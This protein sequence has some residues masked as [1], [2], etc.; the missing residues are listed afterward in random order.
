M[1][2]WA[3]IMSQPL[4]ASGKIPVF[5]IGD[6]PINFVSA[7]DVAALA[8]RAVTDPGLRGQVLQL[9]GPDNLT[10]NQFAAIVQETAGHRG[11]VRHIPRLALQAMAWLTAAA[12]PALARQ[13]RAALAMDTLDM[14]FD[15]AP[16]R[17][18]FPDLPQTGIRQAL[19]DLLKKPDP[20]RQ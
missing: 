10:F 19:N 6:N 4:Q 20:M 12:K 16:T 15:P 14:T 1:Q 2:T 8:G 3:T 13:A 7:A 5:G 18:A 9:G 17:R 11:T